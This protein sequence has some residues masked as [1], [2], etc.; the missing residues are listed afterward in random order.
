M[1]K[2]G[3]VQ[4]IVE[5]FYNSEDMVTVV[6]IPDSAYANQNSCRSAYRSA[7]KRLGYNI[8]VRIIKGDLYLI[9]VQNHNWTAKN[10]NRACHSCVNRWPSRACS[11]CDNLSNFNPDPEKGDNH[12]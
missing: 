6:A 4:Q 7:I 5:N 1:R 12:D 10:Y 3:Y 8:T 9:K 11:T 2:F